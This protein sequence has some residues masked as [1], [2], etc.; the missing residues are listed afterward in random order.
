[1]T[2]SD[3]EIPASLKEENIIQLNSQK[4][5]GLNFHVNNKT[6]GGLEDFIW[7]LPDKNLYKAVGRSLIIEAYLALLKIDLILKLYNLSG[8]LAYLQK[9]SKQQQTK[10]LPE[11]VEPFAIALDQASF[12]YFKR[13]KCL[14]WAAALASMCYKRKWN[15]EFSIGVQLYPFHAH[16]WVEVN[17][18]VINDDPKLPF[19]LSKI[20]SSY[21]K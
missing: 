13:V 20:F 15:A 10:I 5:T 1:M 4:P 16:A 12:Y 11:K 3:L 21:F 19:Q 7:T 8:L 17:H 6:G 2:T 18:L 9:M 14:Q